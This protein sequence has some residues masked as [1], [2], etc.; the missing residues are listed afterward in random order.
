MDFLI[1]RQIKAEMSAKIAAAAE[2]EV[3][4]VILGDISEKAHYAHTALVFCADSFFVYDMDSGERTD[5]YMISDIEK[6]YNKRM[7]GNG[8][9]RVKFVGGQTKDV[10]RFTFAVAAL[11]DAAVLFVKHIHDGMDID[12]AMGSIEATYEKQLSICPKCGRTLSAPGVKCINCESKRK[13]I[14]RLAKYMKPEIGI[15]IFSVIVFVF[16]APIFWDGFCWTVLQCATCALTGA[17]AELLMEIAFSPIGY[18][19]TKR[20]QAENVGK[21]YLEK[22]K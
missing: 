22:R 5:S 21:E 8:V 3:K 10:Y 15:L 14:A 20:W 12:E 4:F 6:I 16:F 9:M 2:K 11:C 18:R 13:I 19:I 7:Y 1:N 17:L